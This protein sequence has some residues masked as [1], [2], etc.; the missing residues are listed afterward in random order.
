M[1]VDAA[2]RKA[3]AQLRPSLLPGLLESVRHNHSVGTPDA[4]LFETGATFW[5]DAAGISR[6]TRRL[7]VVGGADLRELQ[8]AVESLLA[9][10]DAN[11]AVVVTPAQRPGFGKS[12]GGQIEW[13]GKLIGFIGKIDR[14]VADKLDLRECPRRGT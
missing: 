5:I 10:L 9:K 4:H 2:V 12:A 7:A 13:G 8:G 14:S 6:E 1:H 3:D 11:R